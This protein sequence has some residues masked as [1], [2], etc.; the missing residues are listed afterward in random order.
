MSEFECGVHFAAFFS[1]LL[2]ALA[3]S[4]NEFTRLLCI[5]SFTFMNILQDSMAMFICHVSFILS[6]A[7]KSMMA[8]FSKL[9][10]DR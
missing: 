9:V 3:W 5:K 1:R 4:T 2:K 7:E 8:E 6:A 10:Y